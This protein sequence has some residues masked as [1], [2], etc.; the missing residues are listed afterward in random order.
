MNFG[1]LVTD[2]VGAMSQE[3][4]S[5]NTW[6]WS[7]ALLGLSCHFMFVYSS[8]SP[9]PLHTCTLMLKQCKVWDVS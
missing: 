2:Y 7:A 4:G 1:I 6:L 3:L 8:F 9:P 5:G